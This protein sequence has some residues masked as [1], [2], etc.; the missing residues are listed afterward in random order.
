MTFRCC[1]GTSSY[2]T[3]RSMRGRP[4]AA[5]LAAGA[6][7]GSWPKAKPDPGLGRPAGTAELVGAWPKAKLAPEAADAGADPWLA[8]GGRLKLSGG[9]LA[10]ALLPGSLGA[11][12]APGCEAAGSESLVTACRKQA[13]WEFWCRQAEGCAGCRTAARQLWCKPVPACRRQGAAGGCLQR[14]QH[15]GQIITLQHIC[16]ACCVAGSGL[17]CDQLGLKQLPREAAGQR[18]QPAKGQ[19]LPGRQ[20]R[21]GSAG[22]R[23]EQRSQRRGSSRG[24]RLGHSAG[25]HGGRACMDPPSAQQ[26]AGVQQAGGGTSSQQLRSAMCGAQATDDQRLWVHTRLV[27]SRPCTGGRSTPG[28]AAAEGPDG[29]AVGAVPVA[30]ARLGSA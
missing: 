6:A 24:G 14:Q 23:C 30:E 16:I 17:T 10:A 12:P 28:S 13:R 3:H 21:N 5:A 8:G 18:Q 4:E 2:T 25:G 22:R 1:S 11:K 15:V 7:L 29:C 26:P 19:H 9:A 20:A 27:Q